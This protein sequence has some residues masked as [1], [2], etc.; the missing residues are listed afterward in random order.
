MWGKPHRGFESHPLRHFAPARQGAA[1]RRARPEDR[2]VKVV[3]TT[4]S[5]LPRLGGQEMGAFRLAKYLRRKGHQ[6]LILTTEKHPWSG[7]E[8]GG[9]DVVRAPHRFGLADR[10]RLRRLMEGQFREADVVHARNPYRVAALAAPVARRLHRRFVVSLHGLGLLDNPDDSWL[11]RIGHRRYRRRSISM[12][13]AV[14]STGVELARMASPYCRPERMH[15]I[16]NGVDT[17]DFDAART[18]P[19]RL[20]ERYGANRVVLAVRRLVPKNGIQYLVQAAPRILKACPDARIVLGGWGVLEN[21]LKRLARELGVEGGIDFLGRVP[22]AEVPDY[23]ALARVVVFPSRA[24]G[25]SHACLEAMAMGKPVVASRLGGL[26][27]LLDGGRGALV[28][29]FDDR[30]STYDAPPRIPD[31]RVQRLATAI[32]D[33]LDD[34]EKARRVAEAGK[35][36]ALANF[37]WNVLAD[38]ILDVYRGH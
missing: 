16:P 26:E 18:P 6:V 31:D 5:Y 37:D 14:I 32:V 9:F 22:N 2:D 28:E 17:D 7:P 25:T 35:A 19:P 10:F 36:H 24:E 30:T 8:E 33:L 20:L 1:L 15:L 13:D 38:R 34:P 29:L 21:D 3:I 12:A 27:E 23:L 11:R 4:D